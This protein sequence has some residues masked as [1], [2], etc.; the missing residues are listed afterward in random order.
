MIFWRGLNNLP[1]YILKDEET[2]CRIQ[3]ETKTRNMKLFSLGNNSGCGNVNQRK[4]VGDKELKCSEYN[5]N[6]S[7]IVTLN[8]CK[9]FG[10]T[11]E[12]SNT[13][14]EA[15]DKDNNI[16][17]FEP[18]NNEH[19]TE[20]GNNENFTCRNDVVPSCRQVGKHTYVHRSTQ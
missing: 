14:R 17:E 18:I 5:K 12:Y 10:D 1:G 6:I 4:N 11:V 3:H 15:A 19:Y 16:C 20:S 7:N 13:V 2:I 9:K 8:E